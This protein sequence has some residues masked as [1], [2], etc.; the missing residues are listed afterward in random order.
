M[1]NLFSHFEPYVYA[2]TRIVIGL[3][4]TCHG[5]KRVL[6]LF[7]GS[8]E[9]L[10]SLSGI[11]GII[12]LCAGLPLALGL[13]GAYVALLSSGLMATAYFLVHFPKGFWPI[14]NHGELAV[15]YCFVF[16]FMTARGSGIWSLDALLKVNSRQPENK[17]NGSNI[18]QARRD[19]APV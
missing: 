1:A 4:F 18:S 6:G 2:M 16:L 5:L 11:A 10:L 9:S 12:E 17:A 15:V 14:Q 3:L 13:F 7:D 19:S 8:D